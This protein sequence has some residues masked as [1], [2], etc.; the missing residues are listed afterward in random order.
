MIPQLKPDIHRCIAEYLAPTPAQPFEGGQ[1]E[2]KRYQY[3]TLNLMKSS[4]VSDQSAS[5]I[6]PANDVD[7]L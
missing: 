6:N 1:A 2:M 5:F 7:A 3:E 4:K